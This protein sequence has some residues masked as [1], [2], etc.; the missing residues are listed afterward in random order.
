MYSEK[1]GRVSVK[2]AIEGA[3]R[4]TWRFWRIR[5]CLESENL[6]CKMRSNSERIEV[7]GSRLFWSSLVYLGMTMQHRLSS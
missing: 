5:L 6:L 3:F 4:E 1:N 7:L 2:L